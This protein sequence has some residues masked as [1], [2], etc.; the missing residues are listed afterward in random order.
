M[1]SWAFD[2]FN[3]LTNRYLLAVCR[4]PG[5]LLDLKGTKIKKKTTK[6]PTKKPHQ[7][8]NSA[9]LCPDNLLRGDW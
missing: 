9:S 4:V 7:I 2:S 5:S 1:E 8:Q 3:Q 6:K